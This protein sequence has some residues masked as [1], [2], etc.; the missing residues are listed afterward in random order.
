[1][2]DDTARANLVSPQGLIL[3]AKNNAL[4][5]A[6]GRAEYSGCVHRIG[7]GHYQSDPPLDYLHH[8]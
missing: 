7:V 2:T 5:R 3:W 4:A 8:G 6:M 1:M